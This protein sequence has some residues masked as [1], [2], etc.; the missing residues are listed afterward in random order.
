MLVR[1][2]AVYARLEYLGETGQ[3]RSTLKTIMDMGT[4]KFAGRFP[5]F[6]PWRRARQGLDGPEQPAPK[7]P[8][9]EA[10]AGKQGTKT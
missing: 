5:G 9:A 4:A 8:A 3:R 6:E 7:A 2:D 10:P 1:S